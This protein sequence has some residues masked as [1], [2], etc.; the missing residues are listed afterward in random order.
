[1][2]SPVR[3]TMLRTKEL[4]SFTSA[5][6]GQHITRWGW[7]EPEEHFTWSSGAESALEFTVASEANSVHLTLL[8]YHGPNNAARNLTV[9]LNDEVIGDIDLSTSG[10][11]ECDVPFK[12]PLGN[13]MR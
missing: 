11:L 5:G 3:T 2:Q 7:N 9:I 8:P 4:I 6:R 10:T 13:G 12:R 1:M